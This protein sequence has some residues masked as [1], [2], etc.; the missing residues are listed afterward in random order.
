VLALLA[1]A[2]EAAPATVSVRI[3]ARSRPATV[4]LSRPGESHF[5]SAAGSRLWVDGAPVEGER[6]LPAG[7]WRVRAPGKAAREYA[8]AIRLAAAGDEV[9]VVV[10]MP[11]EEHVAAAVAAEAE[12]GTPLE[13]MKALAVVTRSFAA[14][15]RGRHP[16]ADLCDLAHCQVMGTPSPDDHRAAARAAARAT[17]GRVLRTSAGAVAAAPFHAGC[18]GHTADPLEIFGGGDVGAA[19]VPDPGCSPRPW[20]VSVEADLVA[21]VA[22]EVLHGGAAGGPARL[23]ALRLRRGAGGYVIQV[24]DGTAVAGGERFARALDRALGHGRVRSS[25]LEIGP[26]AD[27]HRSSRLEIGPPADGRVRILGGGIGH[28]V[29]LCQEGAARRAAEGQAYPSILRHYFPRARLDPRPPAVTSASAERPAPRW[30]P[31]SR[32]S[33]P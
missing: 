8:G 7:T 21:R 9:A 12:V 1:G 18:G 30:A 32:T 22:G 16:D 23:D 3:L 28:G 24:T 10:R 4:E 20:Q 15:A 6:W 5:A 29:G 26:P 31:L 27:G 2:G 13:A 14:A 33:S 17:A 11:L 25:R 19:A